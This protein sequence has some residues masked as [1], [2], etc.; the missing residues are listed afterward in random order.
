MDDIGFAGFAQ[1]LFMFLRRRIQTPRCMHIQIGGGRIPL[2]GLHHGFIMFFY[3]FPCQF[4]AFCIVQMPYRSG[5]A[6]DRPFCPRSSGVIRNVL[7][8]CSQH[9]RSPCSANTSRQTRC[10]PRAARRA[11]IAR[12]L[13]AEA[14]RTLP[15]RQPLVG[16][17][18]SGSAR[19][20][21]NPL[22]RGSRLSRL[23]RDERVARRR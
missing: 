1:L 2:Y 19:P 6:P 15:E 11:G 22:R 5:S 3:W 13:A 23:R 10:L 17:R 12:D 21:R 14:A 18:R 20:R 7:G 16:V 8:C 9:R 4:P